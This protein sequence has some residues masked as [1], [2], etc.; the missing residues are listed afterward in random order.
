MKHNRTLRRLT[1]AAL[2][3]VATVA[4]APVA[5]ADDALPEPTRAVAEVLPATG[6]GASVQDV[7][8]SLA[9]SGTSVANN[10]QTW[11]FFRLM[12]V[13]RTTNGL[14]PA[15]PNGRLNQIATSWALAQSEASTTRTDDNLAGKLPAG[16]SN[17]Y[18]GIYTTYE[19]SPT[20]AVEWV[21]QFW[22]DLDWIEPGVTDVGVGLV[23]KPLFGSLKE[24][25]LYVIGAGY[26]HS[27]A[28]AG[29]MTLYRF[30]RPDTGTHFYSTSAAER[31]SVI[32][33][34][35]F[36]YEGQVAYV[37]Q[38]SVNRAGTGALNRFYQPGSGM[39][40]YTS[41][42]AEYNRVLGF[43]QYSLDGVAGKVY[44]SGGAGR[45]P[46]YRFFRPAS[47]THFYTASAAEMEQVKT[48]P[49]YT[50]EGTAFFL[51][52]AS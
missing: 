31:N 44:T 33:N 21:S 34:A 2:A 13:A 48:L 17:A 43:P 18:Q 23:E 46:M 25:T 24:Y 37:L 29:E 6:A 15:I 11:D 41:T 52:R 30:S 32:G 47:G 10:Q 12:N 7:P 8:P 19:D 38:P 42:P 40:F 1:A 50:F 16:W 5:S 51:R 20:A 28:Q 14:E 27:T 4:A 9:A 3:L 45:V 36:R 49:G 39:H 22:M 26:T 35:A